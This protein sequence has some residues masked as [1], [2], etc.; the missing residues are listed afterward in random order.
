MF[1]MCRP[2]E[3]IAQASPP[4]SED[5]PRLKMPDSAGLLKESDVLALLSMSRT[6]LWRH[7]K[8]G[9]VPKPIYIGSAK[10]WRAFDIAEFVRSGGSE[11]R[12]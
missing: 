3:S 10:R 11:Y 8:A 5:L 12:L 1:P 7:V 4:V 9:T 2:K 6:S